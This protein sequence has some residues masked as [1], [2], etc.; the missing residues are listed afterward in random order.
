MAGPGPQQDTIGLWLNKATDPENSEE[1]WE[2]IQRLCDLV[3][4]DPE[5][6]LIA[7]RILAHKIQSP[8]EPEAL[9][10]LT[11]LETCINNCGNSFHQEIAKFR[12]LNE[13]IKVISPKF[14]GSWSAHNVKERIIEILYSWTVWFPEE[15]KIQ[16]AYRTLKKNGIIKKDPKLP[17]D[18]LL[19]PPSPRPKDSIFDDEEKSQLLARLLK[20]NHPEDLKAA[21]RLIKTLIK[22]EQE[23]NEKHSRRVAAIN[24]VQS[25][26]TLLAEK[27]SK[28]QK[29]CV[30][31]GDRQEMQNLYERCEKLRPTLFR[32]ASDTLDNDE[33]LAEVLRVNDKLTQELSMYR[34]IVGGRGCEGRSLGPAPA[35]GSDTRENTGPEVTRSYRLIDFTSLD[36]LEEVGHRTA[37][38]ALLSVPSI[39]VLEEE[40]LSLELRDSPAFQMASPDSAPAQLAA[41]NGFPS[42]HAS[43]QVRAK[44]GRPLGGSGDQDKGLLL[45]IGTLPP[46]C[47]LEL[48]NCSGDRLS[49]LDL[50]GHNMEMQPQFENNSWSTG[51]PK[52]SRQQVPVPAVSSATTLDASLDSLFIPLES[53]R[54]SSIVPVTVYDNNGLKVML[55]V[56]SE[57]APERPDVTVLV[58][59]VLSTAPEP[60]QHILFQAAVPKVMRIKLQPS[61]SSE[62]PPFNPLLPPE[63]ISQVLLICNPQK[64]RVRLKYKL[65][66][67]QA[68]QAFSDTGEIHSSLDGTVWNRIR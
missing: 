33:A 25:Q 12:F 32:L 18:K 10:A 59:S 40:F 20:S 48:R 19:P 53:I 36:G 29:G 50:P 68:G 45:D 6:P 21:N 7:T 4:A 64:E 15:S 63:V 65:T 34:Q 49:P 55:H 43:A 62:L 58:L 66:F 42:A 37:G 61:S 23:K 11:V 24:D 5:G 28:Y 2:S 54:P 26:T 41:Q 13:L 57:T 17:R 46:P 52:G 1:N 3:N 35:D 44:G 60:T 8:Q 56:S 39:C 67:T 22:E 51:A 16:T 30:S 14:L 9:R 47:H 31:P 27:L 38:P